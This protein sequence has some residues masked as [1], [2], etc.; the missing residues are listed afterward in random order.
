VT[1]VVIQQAPGSFIECL[2]QIEDNTG[3]GKVKWSSAQKE[4][5]AAYITAVLDHA[6]LKG[7]AVYVVFRHTTAYA[8]AVVQATGMA[9]SDQ[10]QGEYKATIYVDGLTK[11]QKN[12]FS[13]GLRRKGI[14]TRKVQ[15]VSDETN[16]CVRLADAICGFVR[17]ALEGKTLFARLMEKAQREGYVKELR[18]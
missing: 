3:K 11:T 12:K 5:R 10:V 18:G 6:L 4:K 9:I 16:A 8:E 7:I 17:A 15:G 1:V 14:R 2:E 13:A